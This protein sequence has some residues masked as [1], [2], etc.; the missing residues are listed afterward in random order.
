[1]VKSIHNKTEASNFSVK[2]HNSNFPRCLPTTLRRVY[3]LSKST[4]IR[5]ESLLRYLWKAT[6]SLFLSVFILTFNFFFYLLYSRDRR[7]VHDH[8]F[9]VRSSDTFDSGV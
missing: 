8:L 2:S 3:K 9:S 5:Y 4:H 7:G 6:F 1:M